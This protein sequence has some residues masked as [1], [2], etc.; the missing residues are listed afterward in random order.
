MKNKILSTALAALMLLTS[1][2]AVFPISAAA[3][4]NSITVNVAAPDASVD[5]AER[6]AAYKGDNGAYKFD[7]AEQ[8]LK[9]ELEAGYLDSVIAGEYVLYINKYIG[10]V[11]YQNILTGQVLVSNPYNHNSTGLVMDSDICSQVE[12]N[13]SKLS[14][15]SSAATYYSSEWIGKGFDIK[16]TQ[17]DGGIAVTYDLGYKV[18]NLIAPTAIMREDFDEFF[19]EPMFDKIAEHMEANFGPLSGTISTKYGALTSYD[20]GECDETIIRRNGCYDKAR[21]LEATNKLLEYAQKKAGEDAPAVTYLNGII[22]SI[23]SF[24]KNYNMYSVVALKNKDGEFS[25]TAKAE[26]FSRW[27]ELIPGLGDADD[28]NAAYIIDGETVIETYLMVSNAVKGVLG[29]TISAETLKDIDDNTQC[30]ITV[31]DTP[32]FS[33]TLEYTLDEKGTLYVNIPTESISYNDE[34]YSITSITPV[35]YFGCG[36]IKLDGKVTDSYAFIPD[37]SGAI[38]EYADIVSINASTKV[39]V[40]GQDSCYS[41]IDTGKPT[42][43]VTMPVYGMVTYSKANETTKA[44]CGV[45]YAT[46]GFFTIIESGASI[47]SITL[48]S[49]MRDNKAWMYTSFSPYPMDRY[50]LSQT[51]SVGSMS[52]YNML[53]KTYYEG[54]CKTRIT[55]LT[56]PAINASAFASKYYD[57]TYVGMAACYKAYLIEC[58]ILGDI[59]E[60]TEDLPLYIEALGSID[61][62]EKILTFPVTVSIPLTEFEN[63]EQMYLD[64]IDAKGTLAR[65]AQEERDAAK[66][67]ENDRTA[68]AEAQRR[69]HNNKA[70]KYDELAAR[71]DSI[72]NINF[73]LTG[74]ANGGMHF[75]YPAK[76]KW[77]RSVGGKKGFKS[78]VA[79]AAEYN[80]KD[81]YTFGVYPDFDFLYISN[82]AAFD[83]IGLNRSASR[84]V[85][86]RYASKQTWNPFLNVNGAYETTYKM[87]VRSDELDRL[88]GKFDKKYSTYGNNALSVGTLGSDL[89]SNFDEDHLK[90]REQALTDVK[91][92]LS[93]MANERNYSLMTE[94]GNIYSVQYVDH[95]INATIDSS[96]LKDF[97]YT[98]PFYGLVL[99]GYVS[100]AGTPINY[101]GLPNYDILRA[102][103]NGASLYYVLCCQNTNKLKE[104]EELSK[105]YG[106]DYYNWYSKILDQYHVLNGAIGDLQSYEITDHRTVIAE[107]IIDADE[108]RANYA[109]LI[110]EFVDDK[111]N[112]NLRQILDD[113]L[114]AIRNDESYAELVGEKIYIYID[115]ADLISLISAQVNLTAEELAEFNIEAM[116]DAVAAI[117]SGE[118][119][120]VVY[121][122]ASSD[123]LNYIDFGADDIIAADGGKYT[124]KYD[125][126]TDS[127]A[128]DK[129]YDHSDFTCDNGN[130][131][132]VT[133][134]NKATGATQVF[135]LN[136]NTFAVEI[137]V[138]E[139]V[140]YTVA[141]L[142]FVKVAANENN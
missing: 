6:L 62:V 49:E 88:F 105:Y 87:L 22:T 109:R 25:S 85:D 114:A 92:L 13:Y 133:Y 74:F 44:N 29:N 113:T 130:I 7:T 51:L 82:T 48:N 16:I 134:T 108:T 142:G 11:Y 101:S 8:M 20:L 121:G 124:S 2:V 86:N 126:V 57:A 53:A 131:V 98:I 23:N 79:M 118:G 18:E 72:I 97:S 34:Y 139:G 12:I 125:Y 35:K 128:E 76:L 115:K 65:L 110:K 63:V 75:T 100:Y 30:E 54:D 50:D 67:L 37:G 129:D 39:N 104:D 122:N 46:G 90:N 38:V 60:T 47:A 58:G 127:F 84:L 28:N 66:A 81:G 56:D 17:V 52:F 140:S 77:E 61:V 64:F 3:D 24:F 136:Y 107:R 14:D 1:I 117:Y 19:A 94:V 83:G 41:F 70:Q 141:G 9:H 27:R 93:K 96:H 26:E 95:I 40:F 73:K 80:A 106:I 116:I 91:A 33:L 103:E 21:V 4:E 10:T 111:V 89:N 120:E 42:E 102:I 69:L 132:K 99:H 71:V 5:A 135:Y 36:D 31:A 119:Y 55:M 15:A 43:Q 32:W 137:T 138:S 78:L 112:N 45:D 59:L 68:D 123:A